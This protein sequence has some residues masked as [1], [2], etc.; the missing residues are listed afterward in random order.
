M[1]QALRKAEITKSTILSQV[2]S[3]MLIYNRMYI[4]NRRGINFISI[5]ICGLV[6]Y[7]TN[8]LSDSLKTTL[9]A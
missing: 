5:I 7:E 4:I 9:T 8:L 3:T 1:I 6:I 2:V